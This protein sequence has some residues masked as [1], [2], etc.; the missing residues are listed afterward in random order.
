M[1]HY[2]IDNHPDEWDQLAAV[3]DKDGDY[4]QKY[5]ASKM[6]ESTATAAINANNN[7][8]SNEENGKTE[9]NEQSND[10]NKNE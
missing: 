9:P 5:I 4:K 10:E 6:V 7:N 1:T 8:N 2:L 3:Y